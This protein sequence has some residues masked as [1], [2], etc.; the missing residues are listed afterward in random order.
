MRLHEEIED[1]DDDGNALATLIGGPGVWDPNTL[2]FYSSDT[3]S[4]CIIGE[5]TPEMSTCIISQILVLT[6]EDPD[7]QINITL[8]TPG[9]DAIA[10]LAIYDA[11]RLTS[12]PIHVCVQGSCASAGLFI[13]QGGDTRVSYPSSSF[14]HHEPVCMMS[15]NT[16]AGL[17]SHAQHYT[18]IKTRVNDIIKKRSKMSKTTWTKFFEAKTGF[19]FGAQEALEF[20]LID[21]VLEYPKKSNKKKE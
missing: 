16:E 10:G 6:Q 2:A 1:D 17:L 9:G 5:I 7:E 19:Y 8:N 13:L 4:I 20:K 3:R 14:Y 11:M 15:H 21:K 12:C 18:D